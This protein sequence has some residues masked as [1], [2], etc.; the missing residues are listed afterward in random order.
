MDHESDLRFSLIAH[1]RLAAVAGFGVC[2]LAFGCESNL[3]GAPNRVAQ[4]AATGTGATG[5]ASQSGNGGNGTGA[6]TGTGGSAGSSGG[7]T[8]SV[9]C[10]APRAASV[11]ARL[12]SSR[13]Y[14]H[15]VLDL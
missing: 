9:D 5:G 8:D 3:A 15:S 10:S 14:N 11:R 13:Q 4:G 1:P 6:G 7:G 2:I 12:L